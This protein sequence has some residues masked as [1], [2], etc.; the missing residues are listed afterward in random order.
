MTVTYKNPLINAKKK[1]AAGRHVRLFNHE[2]GEY[3]HLS[4]Q[5]VTLDRD[6][7]WMGSRD[8]V[9]ILRERAETRGDDWFKSLKIVPREFG[10]VS[11][12]A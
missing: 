2:S 6:H 12:D 7:S 4:A 5:S 11:I 10:H 1:F 9:R 8:Q 3:L